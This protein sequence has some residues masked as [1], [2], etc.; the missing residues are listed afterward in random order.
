MKSTRHKTTN[1]AI[2]DG[3]ENGECRALGEEGGLLF[4]ED[5]VS[6][7]QEEKSCGAEAGGGDVCTVLECAQYLQR[8]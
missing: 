2:G 7:L 4:D 6:V 5:G 8:L 3:K 1:A